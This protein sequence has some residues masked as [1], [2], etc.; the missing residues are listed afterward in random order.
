LKHSAIRKAFESFLRGR[1]LKLTTQRARIFERA[2]ATHEHF[3]AERLYSWL[4]EEQG[5]KVSRATVY[6]TLSLLVEGGF[7]E[8]LDTGRGELHYEHVLGHAHHD[9]MVCLGCGRIE[10]FVDE[11]I[12]K[13]QQEA[14]RAK[15]FEMVDHDL[16]LIG[17]CRACARERR[18][19]SDDPGFGGAESGREAPAGSART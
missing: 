7:L 6:R 16:K 13:L 5:P 2:F 9:H 15:G 12:E 11:R 10:E 3:T 1:A 14:A 17:Y 19:R 4:H 8:S 18:A